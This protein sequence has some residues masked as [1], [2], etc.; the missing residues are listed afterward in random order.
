M[1]DN[2]AGAVA[3]ANRRQLARIHRR[4]MARAA[5]GVVVVVALVVGLIALWWALGSALIELGKW[6][7][8]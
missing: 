4:Q 5:A 1:N 3:R 2:F 7:D 6:G 8:A